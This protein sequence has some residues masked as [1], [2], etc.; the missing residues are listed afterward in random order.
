MVTGQW[1]TPEVPLFHT[2]GHG[3]RSAKVSFLGLV[4]LRILKDDP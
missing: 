1:S 4:M 3:I 2:V